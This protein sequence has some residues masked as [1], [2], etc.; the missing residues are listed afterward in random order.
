MGTKFLLDSA[1]CIG[2]LYFAISIL[3]Q[4]STT[5]QTLAIL[6]LLFTRSAIL[7]FLAVL[8]NFL[9]IPLQVLCK[10]W[11][12]EIRQFNDIA[13]LT[14]CTSFLLSLPTLRERLLLA[15]WIIPGYVDP[16][17]YMPPILIPSLS[18]ELLPTLEW[19]AQWGVSVVNSGCSLTHDHPLFKFICAARAELAEAHLVLRSFAATSRI[20]WPHGLTHATQTCSDHIIKKRISVVFVTAEHIS[21]LGEAQPASR[22]GKIVVYGDLQAYFWVSL[23]I[24]ERLAKLW[25]EER[26][27]CEPQTSVGYHGYVYRWF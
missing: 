13:W 5:R 16:C 2:A 25:K 1:F 20:P 15:C 22:Y 26:H 12:R 24:D 14:Y 3:F 11:K 7:E 17:T 23:L 9:P 4:F 10:Q 8:S 19:V 21:P 27:K 18:R 6:S